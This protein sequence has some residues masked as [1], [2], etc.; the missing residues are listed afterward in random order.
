MT[1]A[2]AAWLL[3]RL[4][5]PAE[6]LGV[7]IPASWCGPLARYTSLVLEW[8]GHMNLT[9]AR[10]PEAFADD[11]LA[12]A[13]ALLPWL[14]RSAFHFVDV[15]SGAGLPGIPIALARPE[16]SGVLLESSRKKHTFLAHAIRALDLSERLVACHERLEQHV[17]AGGRGAY[18]V[19][20]SRAVWPAGKWLALGRPLLRPGGVLLG[21]E[22]T[23]AGQ[24]PPGATRHPYRLQ[25]RL[26]AVIRQQL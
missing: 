26:R 1:A 22:G 14:P 12:D 11:H 5:E 20:V 8:G 18:D 4:A 6:Q 25:G 9:G 2:S 24:L 13:L 3:A 10:T 21:V 7:E 15:G 23:T 17:A 16:A 19:A